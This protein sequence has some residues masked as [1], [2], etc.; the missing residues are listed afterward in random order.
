MRN[1]IEK[2]TG[3]SQEGYLPYVH[4]RGVEWDFEDLATSIAGARTDVIALFIALETVTPATDR[5]TFA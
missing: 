5:P 3:C 1:R 4:S 2:D